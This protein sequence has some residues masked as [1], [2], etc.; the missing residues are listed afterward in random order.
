MPTPSTYNLLLNIPVFQGMGKF[1]LQDIIAHTKLGFEK[2]EPQKRIQKA[3]QTCDRLIF[4]MSGQIA[5]TSYT[6]DHSYSITEDITVPRPTSTAPYAIEP[7]RLFGLDN[8]CAKTTVSLTTCNVMALDKSEVVKLI[9]KY[10]VFRINLFNLISTRAQTAAYDMWE[11]ETLDFRHKFAR[12]IRMRCTTPYGTKHLNIKRKQLT[13]EM[14]IGLQ[15]MTKALYA[16]QDEGLIH[17]RRAGYDIPQ[18][19]IL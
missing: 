1:E 2:Y 18:I 14:G 5:V 13:T 11:P 7:E 12:F 9:D 16:L 15:N 3:G 17:I 19:E 4:L 10:A 6:S 8:K